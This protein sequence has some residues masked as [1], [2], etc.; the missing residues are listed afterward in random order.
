MQTLQGDYRK[1][2]DELRRDYQSI[3]RDLL[4]GERIPERLTRPSAS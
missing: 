4:L 2:L 1:G 3:S